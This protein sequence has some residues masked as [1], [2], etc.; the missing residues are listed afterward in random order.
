MWEVPMTTQ[1]LT[2]TVPEIVFRHLQERAQ[3]TQQTIEDAALEALAAAVTTSDMLPPDLESTLASLTLLNDSELWHAAQSRQSKDETE[4]L[5]ELNDMRQRD[6]L[7]DTEVHEAA[8]LLHHYERAML[9]RAQASQLLKQRG[10][11]LD[12]LLATE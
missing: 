7:T 9:V 8:I 10:F 4:R 2:L 12:H 11:V 5:A 3:Q 1:E 6:G